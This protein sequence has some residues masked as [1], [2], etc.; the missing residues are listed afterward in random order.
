MVKVKRLS[1]LSIS[2]EDEVFKVEENCILVNKTKFNYNIKR[3]YLRMIKDICNDL[4]RINKYIGGN[5]LANTLSNLKFILDKNNY[6]TI[7]EL[8]DYIFN[9]LDAEIMNSDNTILTH[10]KEI[11]DNNINNDRDRVLLLSSYILKILSVP[12]CDYISQMSNLHYKDIND[13]MY[14]IYRNTLIKAGLGKDLVFVYG[15]F[16]QYGNDENIKQSIYINTFL[17]FSP[18]ISCEKFLEISIQKHQEYNNKCRETL[19]GVK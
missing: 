14:N 16:D 3:T 1:E 17:K 18:L 19:K 10:L 8:G 13:T 2:K 9:I 4:N 15:Y 6:N 5:L 11:A 7:Y 12:L